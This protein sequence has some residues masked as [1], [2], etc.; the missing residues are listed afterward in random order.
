MAKELTFT[1]G[2]TDYAA[3]PVKRN[4]GVNLCDRQ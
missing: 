4:C 2:G 3:A 1:L